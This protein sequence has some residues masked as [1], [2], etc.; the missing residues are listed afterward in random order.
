MDESGRTLGDIDWGSNTARYSRRNILAPWF[1]HWLHDNPLQQP[2]AVGFQT[3]T[4][5]WR[6]Y[7]EWPPKRSV[8]ER[9]LYFRSDGGLSFE[10]PADQEAF[11][12]YVSDPA[13]PVPYRPRPVTPTYPA[14]GWPIWLVQDQRCGAPS[15]RFDVAHRTA[16][17]V[18]SRGNRDLS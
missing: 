13:N 5:V 10:A 3:G 18:H 15:G 11:D 4:N 17:H 9:K 1:A 8:V 6:N 16:E 12:S 14:P 7:D 2:E